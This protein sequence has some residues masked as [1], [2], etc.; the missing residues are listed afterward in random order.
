MMN[1]DFALRRLC[2]IVE[3]NCQK[4]EQ[5]SSYSSAE[6]FEGHFLK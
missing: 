5:S 1:L 6:S 2:E 4:V 3:L